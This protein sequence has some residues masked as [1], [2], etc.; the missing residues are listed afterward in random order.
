MKKIN[1]LSLLVMLMTLVSCSSD[2]EP[3]NLAAGTSGTYNGYTVASCN[4]FSNMVTYDQVV[5]M[6]SSELNKINISYES[7]TWGTITINNADLSGSD[8]N[9]HISGSGKSI[10]SH[11]GNTNEYDCNVEGT[12]IG[13]DLTLSFSCPQ[14]MGG[15]KIDFKQGEIPADIVVPG[16]YNGYTEAK[17]AYFSGMMSDNQKIV[18]TKISDNSY[19]ISYSSDTWGEFVI[20]SATAHYSD[21]MFTI[22]GNGTTKM[23]MNGNIKDYDCSIAG[24]IDIKKEN[25]TFTF[26][27]PTVM[28]G[29]S[30]VFHSGDMPATE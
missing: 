4:Y 8:G 13:K 5:K 17:S 24:T 25:P 20:E 15:L 10:M 7:D 1:F 3:K 27:V 14:V 21:G 2:D 26:S 22:S 19:K 6:S 11:A 18:I 9:I 23:G 28:G 16:T 12:L 30:I 29:L